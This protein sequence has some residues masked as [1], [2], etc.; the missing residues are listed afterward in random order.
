M[1]VFFDLMVSLKGLAPFFGQIC[2]F[3][4]L[5]VIFSH[6]L[7]RYLGGLGPGSVAIAKKFNNIR[8]ICKIG[9]ILSF[10]C[11]LAFALINLVYLV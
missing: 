10:I 1:G 8:R 4:V 3:F 9:A 6:Y 5:V 7:S 2:V 11:F